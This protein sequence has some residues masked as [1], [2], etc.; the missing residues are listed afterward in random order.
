[1][2]EYKL[3][4]EIARWAF[5]V[6]CK[7]NAQWYIAFT[8]PTAGPWKAIKAVGKN[9]QEGRVYTFDSKEKRPD[10]ILVND[11]MKLIL[12]FEAKSDINSLLKRD[13]VTKS[14]RVVADIG[15]MLQKMR[16][17]EY[18]GKRYMYKIVLGLLWGNEENLELEVYDNLFDKYKNEL[19]CYENIDTRLILGI[20]TLKKENS[21]MCVAYGKNYEAGEQTLTLEM[22]SESL[23]IAYKE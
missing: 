4:E 1:M 12:I 20:E 18:W 19:S 7:E 3:T 15:K 21:L 22:L 10:I 16:N 11:S 6:L 17:N 23:N 14:T 2:R 9:G 8:N 5:E 13:Q